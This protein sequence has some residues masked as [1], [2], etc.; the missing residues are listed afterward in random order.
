MKPNNLKHSVNCWHRD[1]MTLVPF[2]LV[3]GSPVPHTHQALLTR[4][5]ILSLL[6]LKHENVLSLMRSLTNRTHPS[7]FPAHATEHLSKDLELRLALRR[8]LAFYGKRSWY[9]KY[10]TEVCFAL[11]MTSAKVNSS[12]RLYPSYHSWVTA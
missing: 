11:L 2:L 12:D 9:L 3:R 5:L 1:G 4:V 6:H 7:T 10:F 8:S